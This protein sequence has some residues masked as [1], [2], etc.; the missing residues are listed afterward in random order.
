MACYFNKVLLS[1]NDEGSALLPQNDGDEVLLPEKG[2]DSGLLSQSDSD[3]L[4]S[5]DVE[6]DSLEPLRFNPTTDIVHMLQD[7]ENKL[8]VC[9][10]KI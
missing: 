7:V 8:R 6:E 10:Y 2:E 3:I 5:Q 9:I 1:Q 4:L